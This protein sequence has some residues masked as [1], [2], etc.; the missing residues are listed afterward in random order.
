MNDHIRK[1][2]IR[3]Q[4]YPYLLK[5][6]AD[7]PHSLYIRGSLKARA[8]SLAVVGPRQHS[9]YA[10]RITKKLIHPLAKAGITIIS[11]LARGIDGIAHATTL[12][13]KGTTIA[14]L[15]AGCDDASMYPKE[16]LKL[17]H[18]ILQSGGALISEYPP[19]ASP[20]KKTFPARNRI[21]A[22]MSKATLVI[23]A[24][25]RSGSLITARC[26]LDYD[27]DV[28]AVPQDIDSP[29]ARGVNHLIRMGA[30]P[31]TSVQD[32]LIHLDNY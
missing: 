12:D 1:I 27:R 4:E 16:H 17:A 13:A 6:I 2:S 24:A 18:R 22:G 31:I 3:D 15:G 25:Q 11:G 8:I 23:E 7:P 29:T 30:Y 21:I 9:A 26:A 14:V 32:V 20:T 5:H 10:A 28:L 19:G